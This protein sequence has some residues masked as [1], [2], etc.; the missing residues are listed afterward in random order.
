M[1]AGKYRKEH[2]CLNCGFHVEKHYCSN[3][4]QPNLEL[5]E[6]FWTFISHSIAHY[7]HFDNKFFQTLTPL[8]T[9]PGQVTLDYLAGKRARYINPV[10]MYI[11]VS[12]VYFLV[13]Y[14]PKKHTKQKE[15]HD[16]V[17]IENYKKEEKVS[18]TV[19]NALKEAGVPHNAIID[20]AVKSI[21]KDLD[22][23]NFKKLSFTDQE[24]ELNRLK[25]ENATLKSDSLS[26]VIEDF[27]DIHIQRND[28][29]YSAYLARQKKLPPAEQDSWYQKLIKKRAITIGEKSEVIQ[30]TL[31]HN[32]PKQYF[33]L[34]PLLAWFIM[35]NFRKNHIYYLDHLIFT[36]HGMMAYFIVEIFTEPIMKYVFGEHSWVSNILEFVVTI[37]L[38]WYMFMAL[39]VFYK[40]KTWSTIF[41]MLWIVILYSVAFKISELVMINLIYYVAT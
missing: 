21:D 39:T 26:D 14:S 18:D 1:S 9:K 20:K 5:K 41:K 15:D 38:A 11:F 35:L 32:R 22:L 24:Q 25:T 6:S 2:N 29:T 7:F 31:E 10:S 12:I 17:T 4:G 40:R 3:C 30:E 34:M 36:I 37:Y 28:S 8:L 33:L 23:K 27:E 16:V 19:K 13:V